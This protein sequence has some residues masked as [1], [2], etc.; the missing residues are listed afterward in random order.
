[1]ATDSLHGFF[2]ATYSKDDVSSNALLFT[3]DGGKSWQEAHLNLSGENIII[4]AAW[5]DGETMYASVFDTTEKLLYMYK[6][7][8]VGT[9]WEKITDN[10][11]FRTLNYDTP[12]TYM[13]FVNEQLGYMFTWG[14][15]YVTTDGGVSWIRN[16]LEI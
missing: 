1:M 7:D 16:V 13:A 3:N 5:K 6:T 14:G 9:K 2:Y 4:D 8:N 10:L 12:K 11:L 15:Y